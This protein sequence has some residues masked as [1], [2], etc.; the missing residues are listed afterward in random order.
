[1]YTGKTLRTGNSVDQ[2]M[3]NKFGNG[4][5]GN[6]IASNQNSTYVGKI[7]DVRNTAGMGAVKVWI[8][9]SDINEDD[10]SAWTIV[11]YAPA[12]YGTTPDDPSGEEFAQTK[13]SYGSWFPVPD[14]GNYVLI[15]IAT[16]ADG[17]RKG[18]YAYWTNCIPQGALND[19][20]PGISYDEKMGDLQPRAEYNRATQELKD[21]KRPVHTPL[22][23][24]LKQQ[25]LEQDLLRGPSSASGR[26]EVPGRSY[27]TLTPRGN[28][29]V[30]DD[31]YVEKKKPDNWDLKEKPEYKPTENPANQSGDK[32]E[33]K[34]YGEG[35]RFR[36]RSGA[37]VLISEQEGLIYLITSSGKTWV[38]LSDDGFADV[39]AEKGVTARTGGDINFRADGN[40]NIEGGQGVNIR[41]VGGDVNIESGANFNLKTTANISAESVGD[42][43][44]SSTTQTTVAGAIMNIKG[45]SQIVLDA[46][47]T[48]TTMLNAQTAT[49]NTLN[50]PLANITTLNAVAA[51]NLP[52]IPPYVPPVVPPAPVVPPV[53]LTSPTLPAPMS[54]Q[55]LKS[56]LNTVVSRITYHEP[57]KLHQVVMPT[58]S[59]VYPSL[60]ADGESD[61]QNFDN[62]DPNNPVQSA[63]L[64]PELA[65]GAKFWN[66]SEDAWK[67][68]LNFEDVVP[69][70]NNSGTWEN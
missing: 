8:V 21:A 60:V 16:I 47:M 52:I 65:I 69:Y 27:G 34:R 19:M 18:S 15:H 6:G 39:F 68:I 29:M 25:G 36:T 42:M 5:V 49:I 40:V 55:D 70:T 45:D 14:V 57:Y 66:M 12:W 30:M 32:P 31:G 51:G 48:D 37:Q 41:S 11:H 67:F 20:L 64:I 62:T 53:V 58:I 44:L 63:E 10:S 23:N 54:L 56:Q 22:A 35:F 24:G 38:E 46:P 4:I 3:S 17:E 7:K 43:T 2:A 28:Q 1:M 13:K 50:T 33:E 61:E 26:R 9:G 59:G